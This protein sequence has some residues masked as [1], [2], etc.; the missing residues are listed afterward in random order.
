[1]LRRTT[2][3]VLVALLLALVAPAALPGTA[4]ASALE[5]VRDALVLDLLDEDPTYGPQSAQS[6]YDSTGAAVP[7]AG[8]STSA[9]GGVRLDRPSDATTGSGIEVL[10]ADG[11][12]LAVGTLAVDGQWSAG[13]VR[14]APV[15]RLLRGFSGCSAFLPR[16]SGVSPRGRL[17]VQDVAYDVD[18]VT[19]TRLTATFRM[20]CSYSSDVVTGTVRYRSD[21]GYAAVGSSV[22][23]LGNVAAG[24]RTALTVALTNRG[25]V[26]AA[27]GVPA[28]PSTTAGAAH[29]DV[30]GDTC[31]TGPLDPGASCAL[32]LAYVTGDGLLAAL[33]LATSD[34]PRGY[35][36][37]LARPNQVVYPPGAPRSVSGESA[38]D[39]IRLLWFRDSGAPMPDGYRIRR[40]DGPSPVLLATVPGPAAEQWVDTSLAK[41]E[42]ATYEIAAY[43]A[44]GEAAS[45]PVT[46]ARQDLPDP[47]TAVDQRVLSVEDQQASA[48]AD[49]MAGATVTATSPFPRFLDVQAGAVELLLQRLPAPGTY[50]VGTG[51]GQ[52]PVG[53]RSPSH[54]CLTY[55]GSV[56]GTVEIR[57]AWV[58]ADLTPYRVDADFHLVCAGSLPIEAQLRWGV[59]APVTALTT[60]A[61]SSLTDFAATVGQA[62]DTRTVTL[63]NPGGMPVAVGA[64]TVTGPDAGAFT[65]SRDDCP[66]SLA[67]GASCERDVAFAPTRSL[68]HGAT[69][70]FSTGSPLGTRQLQLAGSAI[71]APPVQQPI[72]QAV[73]GRALVRWYA[74]ADGG[75]PIT[76]FHVLRATGTGPFT[77]LATL[78]A[79][80]F[81]WIDTAVT[82]GQTYRYRL[83][84]DNQYGALQP[85]DSRTS[86]VVVPHEELVASVGRD[87][88]PSADLESLA[89]SEGH[90]V[91]WGT[92][93]DTDEPALSPDGRWLAYVVYDAQGEAGLWLRAVDGS[94][95]ARVLVD[96][97]GVDELDPAW[98][99]DSSKVAYSA[100]GASSVA[101]RTVTTAPGAASVAYPGGGG[102]AAPSWLPDGTALVAID[103]ATN[104][105]RL[106]RITTAGART[107]LPGTTGA[108]MPAVSP[109]GDR[110][111]YVTTDQDGV[112]HLYLLP[113]AGGTPVSVSSDPWN[114]YDRP[115]WAPDGSAVVVNRF[116]PYGSGEVV[117]WHDT[118]T[119]PGTTETLR[120]A[121]GYAVLS[122]AWRRQDTAAPTITFPGARARTTASA[123][124]PVR[125]VDD[126]VPVGGLAVSCTVDGKVVPRCAAGW[127]GTLAAGSHTLAV[128][129]TDPFGHQRK[130]SWTWV[131]DTTA[132]A[133][134]TS[135][136]PTVVLSGSA[137]FRYAGSD[138]GGVASYDVRYR[139]GAWLDASFGPLTLPTGW[140]GTTATSRT[141]SLAP[142]VEACF[143]VRARDV[144]GN[145]SAWS[146]ERCTSAALDERA[147]SRSAG[148][149]SLASSS[150][151]RGTL[152]RSTSSGRTLTLPGAPLRRSVLVAMTCP[153]C[154]SVEVWY[155][156]TRVATISL[157]SSTVQARRVFVLPALSRVTLS[158]NVRLRSTS[159]RSVV[160]D[161]LAVRRT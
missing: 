49:S 91:P 134:S 110:I 83:L 60:T 69:L 117:L 150:A 75:S 61:G 98:S 5:G 158:T 62:P 48:T 109:R 126:T 135:T 57:E 159:S 155:D 41:G 84:T 52:V 65:V 3:V 103:V 111:A 128:T 115:T 89:V 35:V 140:A 9:P 96:V 107:A 66:A 79:T 123:K 74:N 6:V 144:A 77:E 21:V 8:P 104:P 122:A 22:T 38:Y 37:V 7:V 42:A 120:A 2:S 54:S 106:L 127:S 4:P 72:V 160:I 15:V 46:V 88:T 152:L 145:V 131:V 26:P 153:T 137:T 138:A 146:A 67:P 1:M 116:G 44:G 13:A 141:L 93:Q 19:V 142:G 113:V 47:P 17:D 73:L 68:L 136:L 81:A 50:E 133:V 29:L 99:P 36:G 112:D 132:P 43:N 143:S 149:T 55:G 33:R 16:V 147:L 71:G 87:S 157:V 78:P 53:V 114:Y 80:T 129:A 100:A 23:Y 12:L 130:A 121:A 28:P 148:W 86:T 151:Y 39:G 51:P 14:P 154:G 63:S 92:G 82:P 20:L 59:A 34:L 40:I 25:S 24:S 45:A 31:S 27:L 11:G 118:G 97:A 124:V 161:G 101:L 94:V 90:P 125:V 56:A 102:A 108:F 18:G 119:L 105:T 30:V 85:D 139:K 95:P 58:K 64:A 32:D 156:T 70:S 10:P 76:G